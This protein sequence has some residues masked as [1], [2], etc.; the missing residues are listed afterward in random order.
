[1]WRG[2]LEVDPLYG[3]NTK[4]V[5]QI[6]RK[7]DLLMFPNFF[8]FNFEQVSKI[9]EFG[10]PGVAPFAFSRDFFLNLSLF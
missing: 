9:R 2:Q 10:L 7:N 4:L 3:F 8:F 1:M 6:Y 5:R